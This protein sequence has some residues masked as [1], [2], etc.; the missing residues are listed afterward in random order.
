[1]KIYIFLFVITSISFAQKTNQKDVLTK[2][3]PCVFEMTIDDLKSKNLQFN[4]NSVFENKPFKINNFRLKIKGNASVLNY[5][6]T[7][8]PKGKALLRKL[9]PGNYITIFNIKNIVLQNK[10]LDNSFKSFKIKIIE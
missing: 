10:I 6:N 8:N 1:M 2:T 3:A 5:G 7:L 9:Y 4:C